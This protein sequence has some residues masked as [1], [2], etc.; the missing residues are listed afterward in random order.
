MST[1]GYVLAEYLDENGEWQDSCLSNEDLGC[2]EHQSY[3][4]YAFWSGVRNYYNLAAVLPPT[5]FELRSDERQNELLEDCGQGWPGSHHD[6][7]LYRHA[8]YNMSLSTAQ[9]IER[10]EYYPDGYHLIDDMINFD[11]DQTV[12]ISD[13]PHP[14]ERF[15]EEYKREVEHRS[16]KE[17]LHPN[18]LTDLKRLRDEFG[19]GRLIFIYD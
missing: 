9:D 17:N 6:N 11:Y 5:P 19:V 4:K 7:P 3:F 14:F 2:I 13:Q 15:G 12:V 16:Y 8:K 18:Y 10:H 1:Y